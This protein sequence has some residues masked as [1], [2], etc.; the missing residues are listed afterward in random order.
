MTVNIDVKPRTDA[1]VDIYVTDGN[2]HEPLLNSSQGYEG[3]GHAVELVERLFAA[4]ANA[5]KLAMIR[6][7][8]LH[9]DIDAAA[10]VQGIIALIDDTTDVPEPVHL[11]IHWRNGTTDNRQIR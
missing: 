10:F 8:A 6:E 5:R 3:H 2:N 7:L 1:K 11:T 4:D 9:D